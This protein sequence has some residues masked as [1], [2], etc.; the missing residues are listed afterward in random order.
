MKVA[1]M[2]ADH[3]E[4]VNGK[5]YIMGGGWSV[6]GPQ[7]APSAIAIKIEVPWTA[8]N[9]KHSMR[10]ELVDA[11]FRPVLTLGPNGTKVP[12]VIDAAFEAGRAPGLLPGSPLDVPFAVNIGP[13][14]LNSG[15]RFIWR[16]SIDGESQDDWKV[17]FATRAPSQ[18]AITQPT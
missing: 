4:V 2:L 13:I 1:M 8:A 14:P 12:I 9:Q 3:A 10:L 5:L 16:L 18:Q 17:S 6:T 7:P 15:E 11:D